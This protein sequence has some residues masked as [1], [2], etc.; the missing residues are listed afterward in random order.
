MKYNRN[1]T[2]LES[3]SV[4]WWPD[5]LK[6]MET[7]ASVVPLLIETQDKFISILTLSVDGKPESVM[8][9]IEAAC[10]PINLF[11][12]HLMVLSDFGSEPFQ[13]VNRDFDSIYPDGFFTFALDG[14]KHEYKFQSLPSK[15]ALTNKKMSTDMK[16]L[17]LQKDITDFYRDIVML[18][19]YAGNDIEPN[20]AHIF[21]KC[22]IG[23]MLGNKD[24]LTEFIK[25]RYIY[26]SRII[27]GSQA[28]DLGNAAQNYVHDY[29][30]ARLGDNF[31]LILNGYIPGVTQNDGRTNTTF[32]L[33]VEKQ[34]KYVAIE[35][36]FQVT[37]NSTIERKGGQ[38]RERFLSVD[39][40]GN[41]IAYIIDGAG[42]FQRRSALT[43]ICENSHCTVAFSN[44][45][46]DVLIDFIM[47]VM[48]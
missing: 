30:N 39:K 33:V 48:A 3:A 28:N 11:V 10:F 25:Q 7:E 20:R 18:L 5:N 4:K 22:I 29:L 44:K 40:T 15:G 9:I 37:T 41:F 21:A 24:E 42:N 36:S 35:I 16:G 31:N 13:R 6:K 19:L 34:N 46:F 17:L 45:E 27:G 32:D 12:K 23:N 43:T 38:A 2:E 8:D 1:L 26:V 47:E 14:K